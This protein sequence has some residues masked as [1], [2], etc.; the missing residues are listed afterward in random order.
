MDNRPINSE[1]VQR[2]VTEVEA[3]AQN[4]S[5]ALLAYNVLSTQ[6][7][8]GSLFSGKKFMTRRAKKHG[9]N[10]DGA[11]TELGNLLTIMEKG[12]NSNIE[13]AL[14]A[15]FAIK[16]FGLEYEQADDSEREQLIQRF[17]TH[18]D[19][20]EMSTSYRVYPFIQKLLDQP[21]VTAIYKGIAQ[22][23]LFDDKGEEK[24]DAV[25]R[26]R[27][28]V[29]LTALK[30]ANTEDARTILQLIAEE[31][32]DPLTSAFAQ[33]AWGGRREEEKTD[34]VNIKGRTGRVP[35]YGFSTL[36]R[37]ITG[38]TLISWLLRLFSYAIGY[39]RHMELELHKETLFIHMRTMFLGRLVR[40][41]QEIRRLNAIVGGG[42]HVRYPALHLL[43]GV[44]SLSLGILLGGILGFDGFRTGG[45]TLLIAAGVVFFGGCLDLVLDTLVPAFANKVA[46]DIYINAR[47]TIRIVDVPIE[48]TENFLHKLGQRFEEGP[49]S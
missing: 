4:P 47:Q 2:A 32:S 18:A 22:M 11:V 20:L 13:W 23:V 25:I 44:I 10:R 7:E 9:V 46:L 36:L 6:A 8:G 30:E 38:W 16:G 28:A 31:V 33:A 15:A 45:I 26:A 17:I 21:L 39:R 37:V 40:E 12:P 14:V 43:V 49:S 5:L 29:R 19:W 42:R 3:Q 1:D 35:T 48:D 34:P 41:E 24:T 27:N